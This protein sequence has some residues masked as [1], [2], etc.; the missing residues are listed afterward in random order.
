MN[1]LI[2]NVSSAEA[3]KH[4]IGRPV[5]IA[6]LFFSIQLCTHRLRVAGE[7]ALTRGRGLPGECQEVG[8][9]EGWGL[10]VCARE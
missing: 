10:R 8:R 1:Y 2:Q 3:K 7:M 4:D 5:S 6:V 9:G